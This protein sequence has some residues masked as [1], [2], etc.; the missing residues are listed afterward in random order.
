VLKGACVRVV[1][2]GTYRRR[3]V[4]CVRVVLKGRV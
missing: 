3:T 2:K 1:L 4:T